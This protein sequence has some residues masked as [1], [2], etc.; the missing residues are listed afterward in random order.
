MDQSTQ[1]QW[2]CHACGFP[3]TP[4]QGVLCIPYVEINMPPEDGGLWR[5]LHTGCSEDDYYGIDLEQVSD[6]RGLLRWTAHL[7]DKNWLA[8]TNWSALIRSVLTDKGVA[9]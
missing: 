2:K 3:I 9:V 5:S 7:M 6:Y 8:Q 4:D 1:I